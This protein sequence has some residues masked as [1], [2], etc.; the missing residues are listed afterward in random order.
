MSPLPIIVG[1]A[2]ALFH[3]NADPKEQLLELLRSRVPRTGMVE[4]VFA[5]PNGQG[6]QRAGYD[7]ATGAWYLVRDF[8]TIGVQSDGKR[9]GGESGIGRT[10]IDPKPATCPEISVSGLIP[11]AWWRCLTRHPDLIVNVERDG[12]NFVGEIN[13]PDDDYSGVPNLIMI[14]DAQ[15][16]VIQIKRPEFPDHGI[17][18]YAENSPAW[19]PLPAKI[20]GT[21]IALVSFDTPQGREGAFLQK[22]V[23]SIGAQVRF[24]SAQARARGT[25]PSGST[26]VPNTQNPPLPGF[27]GTEFDS[28]RWTLLS[29]GGCLAVVGIGVWMWKRRRS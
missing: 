8:Q 1:T 21:D 20:T 4:A 18:I 5:E 15:G 2:I 24:N 26:A 23:E 12:D 29:V 27:S 13:L 11:A 17:T 3:E 19:C 28:W 6:E 14:F 7:F 22:Q 10:Q 9:Y 16:R 25:P